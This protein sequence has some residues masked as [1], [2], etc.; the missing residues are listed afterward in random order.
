MTQPSTIDASIETTGAAAPGTDGATRADLLAAL[1]GVD[2]TVPPEPGADA[3][4]PQTPPTGAPAA[5]TTQ[6]ASP[7][8][9]SPTPDP[10]ADAPDVVRQIRAR[11]KAEQTRAEART[12]AEQI[13]AE[14]KAE[15]ER[16]RTE[17][18]EAGA[19]E[20]REAREAWAKQFREA[21]LAAIKGAGIDTA[22]LVADVTGEDTPE[23]RL[24]RAQEDQLRAADERARKAEEAATAA[25]TA[26]QTQAQQMAAWH[27]Q[28]A[29]Q[30]VIGLVKSDGQLHKAAEAAS[31]ALAAIGVAQSRDEI[32]LARAHAAADTIKAAGGVASPANVVQYLEWETS[33]RLGSPNG[34]NGTTSAQ[35]AGTTATEPTG[36]ANGTT[37]TLSAAG[38]SERRS[39]PKPIDELTPREQ[40]DL[41]VAEA[42]AALRGK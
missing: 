30:Q 13:R 9:A 23:F 12:E 39:A 14:A 32:L 2:L 20:A 37:R 33:R 1:E 24:R 34:A 5:P 41:L 4:A 10:D 15:A 16:W 35:G 27:R 18:R 17:A 11:E 28:Q 40:R 31:A 25:T 7:G 3:P 22:R 19:R 38:A 29:E 21:P 6:P 26:V 8:G 42:E 36:R